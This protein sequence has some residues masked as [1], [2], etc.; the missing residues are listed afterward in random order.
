MMTLVL[1]NMVMI[2]YI[3]FPFEKYARLISDCFHFP[4]IKKKKRN[5]DDCEGNFFWDLLI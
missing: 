3:T 5:D 1:L 4:R 2:G